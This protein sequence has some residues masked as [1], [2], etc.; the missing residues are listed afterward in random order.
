[1]QNIKTTLAGNI[2]TIQIDTTQNLGPSKSGKTQLVATSGGNKAI[3]T[4]EGDVMIG[5]NCYRK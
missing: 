1:M 2:L 5:I 3:K 4:A